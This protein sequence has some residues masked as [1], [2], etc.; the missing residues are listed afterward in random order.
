MVCQKISTRRGLPRK[1]EPKTTSACPSR[2]GW[3]SRGY[4]AGSYSRS[5][6]W[7]TTTSPVTWRTA[8]RTAAPLPWFCGWKTHHQPVLGRVRRL[9]L[10]GGQRI[11]RAVGRAVVDDDDLLRDRHRHHAL[12]QGAHR[13][14]LVEDGDDDREA[15]VGAHAAR[16]LTADMR[17]LK[18]TGAVEVLTTSST[19]G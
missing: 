2:I 4:S 11:A 1:R 16:I 7:M 13:A 8:V 3:I 14:R 6:S 19:A 12:E 17:R 10:H 15:E 18:R 5:A 9:R